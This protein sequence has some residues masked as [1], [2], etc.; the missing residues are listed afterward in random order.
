ME[1]RILDGRTGAAKRRAGRDGRDDPVTHRHRQSPCTRTN[2][3]ARGVLS[4]FDMQ[5]T[6]ERQAYLP[7]DYVIPA[8]LPCRPLCRVDAAEGGEAGDGPF[9]ILTLAPLE[10]PHRAWRRMPRPPRGYR[11]SRTRPRPVALP[12]PA[13]RHGLLTEPARLSP[14]R[15]P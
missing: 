10:D 15:P 8:D 4:S 11:A 7:G 1:L 2:R 9:Q 5:R 3:P 6:A 12:R 13:A 14:S